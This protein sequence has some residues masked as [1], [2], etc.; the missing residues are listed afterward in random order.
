MTIWRN[1]SCRS[2]EGMIHSCYK[3]SL[4]RGLADLI[5]VRR[6][7]V[8]C[9]IFLLAALWAPS[10][11]HS[12][13]IIYLKTGS[14]VTGEIVSE[15]STG[16]YYIVD[17]YTGKIPILK[18]NVLRIVEGQEYLNAQSQAEALK[19]Q[20][21]WIKAA[22][23]YQKAGDSTE[24]PRIREQCLK[25][26]EAICLE[27]VN[28]LKAG[29]PQEFALDQCITVARLTQNPVL[30][31]QMERMAQD[32]LLARLR[33]SLEQGKTAVHLAKYDDALKYFDQV[34]EPATGESMIRSDKPDKPEW[35]LIQEARNQKARI[36][37]E[38]ARPLT[39]SKRPDDLK[40]AE[41]LL[42]LALEVQP[43]NDRANYL[44][45]WL[46]RADSYRAMT[47]LKKVGDSKELTEE[48]RLWVRNYI[49]RTLARW[50]RRAEERERAKLMQT[51]PEP[52]RSPA[53]NA[54]AQIKQWWDD[55]G[56]QGAG[57]Y[58]QQIKV[59]LRIAVPLIF[60][61]VFFFFIP[62]RITRW[63]YLKRE[64][65]PER[66][67]ARLA[68]YT[69]LIGL[70]VYLLS[71][72][73][74][75]LS[76]KPRMLCPHCQK[77][78]ESPT[79]FSD[80]NFNRCPYC[81]KTIK[82]PYQLQDYIRALGETIARERAAA[83]GKRGRD[84]VSAVSADSTLKLLRA[85]ITFA[86]RQRAS[87]LHV[88]AEDPGD[89]L[90]R[91]RVDGVMHD[92]VRLPR[93]L[94]PLS[95][96]AIKNL[97]SLDIA[98]RRVPQDGH[99]S[100]LVD[101]TELNIRVATT[102]TRTG[103]KAVLRLLM[104]RQS[105]LQLSELGFSPE[106]LMKY[107]RSIMS[108]HGIVLS[109][110][111]TGS[112]KTTTLY[113]SLSILTDG[114]RNI[115]TIEDPIEYTIP[116][117]N[118]MQVNTKAGLT[119]GTALRSILRQDPDVIMVGEIRDRE[120]AEIACSAAMTGHLVFSTLHTIDASTALA[121]LIDLG[122]E[123]KQV[124]SAVVA[125]IAQ[126]L[127]RRVCPHC[128]KPYRP[129]PEDIRNLGLKDSD[130]HEDT[131]FMQGA[132]CD[133]CQK[134]GYYGRMGLFEVLVVNS[135]KGNVMRAL[136]AGAAAT[137]IRDAARRDGMRSL[138]EEGVLKV[139]QGETTV[140]EVLRVTQDEARVDLEAFS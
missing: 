135:G 22:L 66:D 27:L 47:Y 14:S 75:L 133:Q 101:K 69:G 78:L 6:T 126:R 64:P 113:S 112:G 124:A 25:E 138:R 19:N 140:P 4:G 100:L 7:G 90:F 131:R 17:V 84:A 110:G 94:H 51:P 35:E 99:F 98:E 11:G 32:V 97:A 33:S 34:I 88:E 65:K 74:R 56:N 92:A 117:V 36:Y 85:I 129:R 106:G 68:K 50:E 54:L 20:K 127:V 43:D 44:L 31:D 139:L 46:I 119:F 40:T 96:T 108:P 1:S 49:D 102:P 115:V 21:N 116:G 123:P 81:G 125:I 118:Q 130:I 104:P 45:G 114:Q 16:D 55:F 5:R 57:S 24:D 111:P 52:P 82:A 38:K 67:Y 30:I 120:T 137:T 72:L 37:I 48:E 107:E 105:I 95:I 136:E 26:V 71:L 61:I 3:T 41:H 109:T 93:S 79:V 8:W 18:S 122:V 83:E 28:E 134:T 15:E 10:S 29:N 42:S 103:E 77:P 86:V 39:T 87:D 60:V 53:S 62:Y 80:W 73:G 23:L 2:G 91:M 132:G 9:L 63:H 59:A 128:A 70:A 121:R 76:R 58:E 89:L 12:A 13:Q